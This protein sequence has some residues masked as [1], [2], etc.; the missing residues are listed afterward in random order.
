VLKEGK[1]YV[2][3]DKVLRVKIIWLYNDIPIAGHEGK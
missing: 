1:I 2:L 3:K